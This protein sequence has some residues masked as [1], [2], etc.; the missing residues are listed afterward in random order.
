MQAVGAEAL[1]AHVIEQAEDE[2]W[3]KVEWSVSISDYDDMKSP[4]IQVEITSA[5]ETFII[6]SHRR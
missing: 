6:I 2:D 4:C 1:H 3:I 5:P